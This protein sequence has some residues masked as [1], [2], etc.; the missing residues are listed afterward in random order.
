MVTATN[1][2]NY[3][4]SLHSDG[5]SIK[6]EPPPPGI[7]RDGDI[8]GVDLNYQTSLHKLSANWDGFGGNWEDTDTPHGK[9]LSTPTLKKNAFFRLV[10]DILTKLLIGIGLVYLLSFRKRLVKKETKKWPGYWHLEKKLKID[11]KV[12]VQCV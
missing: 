12:L 3:T 8:V 4:Y 7:V 5:V 11:I 10:D 9:Q 2:L 1:L 6:L